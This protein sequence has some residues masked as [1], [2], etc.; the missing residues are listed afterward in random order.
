MLNILCNED[1]KICACVDRTERNG[2]FVFETGSRRRQAFL[3]LSIKNTYCLHAAIRSC[4]SL[5]RYRH[6][7]KYPPQLHA[8]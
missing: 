4:V 3:D 6:E 1:I 7:R 5:C 2:M 8:V